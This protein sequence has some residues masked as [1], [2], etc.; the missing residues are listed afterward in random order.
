MTEAVLGGRFEVEKRTGRGGMAEG[1]LSKDLLLHGLAAVK[2]LREGN[3]NARRRF[4][5]EGR[6]LT[7]LRDPH[8]V[9]VAYMAR[10]WTGPSLGGRLQG[11]VSTREASIRRQRGALKAK[12]W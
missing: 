7:N 3:I 1:F 5:D 4:T 8:P 6:L 9:Q 12:R 11:G 10:K 2:V